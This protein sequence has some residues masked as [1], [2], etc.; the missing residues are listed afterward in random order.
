MCVCVQAVLL[1][2]REQVAEELN[3]L[4]RDNE[5]LQGKHRLH[6]ML[7]QQEDFHMPTTVQV[8]QHICVAPTV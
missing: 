1:Q 3:R 6:M 4:Q 5:S 7:Q 2:S 8:L